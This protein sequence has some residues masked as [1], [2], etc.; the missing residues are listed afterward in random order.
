MINFDRIMWIRD[1]VM[2]FLG[3]SGHE[4]LF[5]KLL[6]VNNNLYGNY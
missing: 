4:L 6:N 3:I 2:K 5:Y 1:R